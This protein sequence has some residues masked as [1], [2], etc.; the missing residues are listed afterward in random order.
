[1]NKN[2]TDITEIIKEGSYIPEID[3]IGIPFSCFKWKFPR[4]PTPTTPIL[5]L[6]SFFTIKIY[7]TRSVPK[8]N[9][10]IKEYYPNAW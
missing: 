2:E 7:K 6:V 3:I 4:C 9:P 1:M 8:R 5:I 10:F